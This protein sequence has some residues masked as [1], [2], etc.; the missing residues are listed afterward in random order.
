MKTITRSPSESATRLIPLWLKVTYTAFMAVLIPVYWINYGPTNF[1]YFCDVALLITL[2]AV[3]AE[4][5]QAASIAAVGILVPQAFWCLDFGIQLARLMTGAE[6][7]GMTAY[8]FDASKPPFLRGLSLFHGWLPFLLIFLLA[9]LGYEARALKQW[10]G[11]AWSLC[12]FAFF[13]LPPAG[14]KL[15]DPNTPVNVNYVF[16]LDDTQ[17]QQWMPAGVYLVVWMLAL[18][19]LAFLPT[20]LVLNKLASQRNAR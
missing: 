16:G 10:T 18:F 2:Y 13:A 20:H 7:S 5:R 15:A 9:R 14:A 12:L 1:L 11:I 17:A 8:M 4:S 6:H 3:W 19:A